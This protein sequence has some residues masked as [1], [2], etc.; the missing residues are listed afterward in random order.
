MKFRLWGW[1]PTGGRIQVSQ[2]HLPPNSK[3]SSDFG[4]FILKMLKDLKILANLYQEFFL[5]NTISGGYPPQFQTGGTSCAPIPPVTT[6]ILRL[7]K[8]MLD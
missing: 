2:N 4:H 8:A 5:K 6:P 7:D 3:F 1:I